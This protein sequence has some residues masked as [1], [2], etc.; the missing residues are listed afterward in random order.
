MNNKLENRLVQAMLDQLPAQACKMML[1]LLQ[2]TNHGADKS[3]ASLNTISKWMSVDR[4]TTKKYWDLLIEG[5]WLKVT[6]DVA[7]QPTITILT[8]NAK[9]NKKGVK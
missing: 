8:R 2:D 4:Q 6:Y 1:H 9:A 5:G 3:H 7:S